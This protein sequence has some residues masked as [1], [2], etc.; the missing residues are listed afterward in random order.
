MRIVRWGVMAGL[1][2]TLAACSDPLAQQGSMDPDTSSPPPIVVAMEDEGA[3]IDVV[4]G[5]TVIIGDLGVPMDAVYVESDDT[6]IAYP[7][8]PSEGDGQAGVVALG[9]G[10]TRVTVWG[11]FPTDAADLPVLS[12]QVSVGAS[13][14]PD[15]SGA[16]G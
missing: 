11:S 15:G 2:L 1:L 8:Q 3:T 4:F 14:E 12:F 10:V 13:D 5:Q 9:E 7:V 6:A 16:G